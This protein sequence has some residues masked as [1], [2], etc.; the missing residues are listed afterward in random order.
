MTHSK[1]TKNGILTPWLQRCSSFWT[2][3][4]LDLARRQLVRISL[5]KHGKIETPHWLFVFKFKKQKRLKIRHLSVRLNFALGARSAGSSILGSWSILRHKQIW[6]MSKQKRRWK[7]S[8]CRTVF[9]YFSDRGRRSSVL[10]GFFD[11]LLPFELNHVIVVPE[12]LKP[13]F[14]NHWGKESKS[15]LTKAL[16]K[17]FLRKLFYRNLQ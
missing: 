4:E 8:F 14:E 13:I 15:L 7:I 11:S 16:I 12:W 2:L 1:P 17:S 10:Y 6:K 3:W 9:V 5:H